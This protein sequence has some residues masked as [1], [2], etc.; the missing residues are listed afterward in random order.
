MVLDE[1]DRER[2]VV[3]QAADEVAELLD[4]LVVQPA[5][6]LVEEEELRPRDERPRELDPLQRREREADGRAAR[7]V[8]EPDV[9]ERLERAL[10]G[11]VAGAGPAL[12]P[13]RGRS[14]ARVIDRKSSTFWNVRAMPRRT[15]SCG[16]YVQ[17]VLPSKTISPESGL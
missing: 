17:Q 4:L 15:I 1:Q 6:R 16:R 13:R 11:P 8:G 7:A 5:R 3:A 12:Q 14:R 9:V 2:E 10:L